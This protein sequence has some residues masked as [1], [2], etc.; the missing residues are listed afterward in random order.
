MS[1]PSDRITVTVVIPA[2]NEEANLA[3]LVMQ[4]LAKPWSERLSLDRVIVVDDCSSD[5]TQAVAQELEQKHDRVCVIRHA[6]RS[7]KNAG[8]RTGLA[9]CHSDIAVFV[10]ADLLL[11][12]DCLTKTAYLLLDDP[13]IAMASC[14]I[15]PLPPRTWRERAAH[16]QARLVS[17]FKRLGI[18]YMSA[19]FALRMPAVRGMYLPDTT[20]DDAYIMGWL[21]QQGFRCAA[22]HDAVAYIRASAG[23]RDFAKQTLRGRRGEARA[24]EAWHGATLIPANRRAVARAIVRTLRSDPL[25]FALYTLWYSVIKLTPTRVWLPVVDVSKYDTSASTKDLGAS[26]DITAQ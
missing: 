5:G 20:A 26:P 3:R 22:R 16:T 13:T 23:L 6:E 2:F 21:Q 14:I 10:D 9:A 4:V 8:I 12:R 7:G 18:G 15:E 17:E 1:F 11:G 25:G 19:V 24:K